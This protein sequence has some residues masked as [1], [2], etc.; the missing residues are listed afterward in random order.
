MH[1]INEAIIMNIII[2]VPVLPKSATCVVATVWQR[3]IFI[4]NG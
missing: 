1:D 2:M 4:I 3:I